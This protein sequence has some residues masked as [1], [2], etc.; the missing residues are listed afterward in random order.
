MVTLTLCVALLAPAAVAAPP[1]AKAKPCKHGQV[2]K[3]GRCVKKPKKKKPAPAKP[4]PS[5][6]SKPGPAGQAPSTAGPAVLDT[7]DFNNLLAGTRLYRKDAQGFQTIDF[8]RS[9]TLNYH[10]E[11]PQPNGDVNV[12]DFQGH[13]NYASYATSQ[14]D[15]VEGVV[16]Y[17]GPDPNRTW[18]VIDFYRINTVALVGTGPGEVTAFLR[19]PEQAQGC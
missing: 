18:M 11:I 10:E 2:R 4:K 6:P 14:G 16:T 9:G 17:T 19:Q 7:I 15:V 5:A 1:A 3:K 8:C 12:T 13:F